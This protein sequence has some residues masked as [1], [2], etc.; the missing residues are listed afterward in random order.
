MELEKE[1]NTG[2]SLSPD[3]KSILTPL[4]EPHESDIMLVEDF[5]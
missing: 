1:T 3:G 4:G 5:R 2:F